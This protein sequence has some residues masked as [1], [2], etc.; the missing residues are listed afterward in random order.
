MDGTLFCVFPGV[1]SQ[2][3]VQSSDPVVIKPGT[4][5]KLSC[6]GFDYNFKDYWMGWVRETSDGTFQWVSGVNNGGSSTYYHDSVKGRCTISRDNSN[7]MLHL[8]MNEMKS[9]DTARYYCA[10]DTLIQSNV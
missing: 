5:Y 7:N 1:Q 3:L 6:E 9:E 8:Q 4:S 10:R 2:R